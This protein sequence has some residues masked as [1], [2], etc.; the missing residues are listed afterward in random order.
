M[1]QSN[2]LIA[3]KKKVGVV[4]HPQLITNMKQNK[5]EPPLLGKGISVG[6]PRLENCQ[7][8]NRFSYCKGSG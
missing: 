6:S 7:R 1:G 8:T 3:N 2:W 4:R 5:L